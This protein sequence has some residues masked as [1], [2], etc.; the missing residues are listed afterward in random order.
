MLAKR[1]FMPWYQNEFIWSL[2]SFPKELKTYMVYSSML[3]DRILACRMADTSSDLTFVDRLL[4]IS[5][6]N[7]SFNLEDVKAE[8]TT[9][10]YGVRSPTPKKTPPPFAFK[11][12]LAACCI[13]R[14]PTRRR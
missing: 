4:H 3:V 5:E 6:E 10:L 9:L 1:L 2:T 12:V 7:P 11:T 13:R 14:H 8:A